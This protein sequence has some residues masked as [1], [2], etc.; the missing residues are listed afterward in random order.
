MEFH[1]LLVV[2]DPTS[3]DSQPSLER[4]TWLA[5]RSN[6]AVELLLCEYN[7]ALD[8]G[9]FF[10]GPAQHKAR[11]SLLQNR[12]KWLEKLAQPLRDAGI[13]VTTEARWGKPLHTMVLQ[14]VEELKPDLV[15]RDAHSHSLLQ[16]LFFNNTSWQLIRHCPAPLWLVR[17]GEWKGE[18]VC[19]AVDPVHS[20]DTTA[21]LDH[22]LV[23]ATRRIEQDLGMQADYIHSYAP[24][25]RTMVFDSELV[26]AYD[27]YVERSAKQHRDAFEK[28]MV[29]YPVEKAHRHLLEGFPEESIPNFVKERGVDLL[30][31][32]AISR[33]N[34]ENALI[35]N[36]AER[37]LEAVQT[38]LLVI[39][40]SRSKS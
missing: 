12:T 19:A 27:Q 36:T 22:L 24:L 6:A 23:Q 37:V 10:D 20:A 13:T 34:L 17:D 38:D 16:R 40:P 21:A 30:V 11:E 15:L 25:P 2:I 4:A 28:L 32:G 9:Y 3:G 14:R 29:D 8:G 31:M 1:Q 33:G 5:Q 39:K 18:R 35:G 26:A 7:S